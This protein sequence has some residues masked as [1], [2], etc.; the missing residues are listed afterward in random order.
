[1]QDRDCV[2]FLRRVLPS[3]GFRWRGYRKVRRQVCR[4][5]ARRMEELGL[6]TPAEYEARLHEDDEERD[7]LRSLCRV[8][9]SR[10]W[11]DRGM[12]DYLGG[13][14][15]PELATSVHQR[16]EETLRALSLGSASGEEPYSLSILWKLKVDPELPSLM[17]LLITAAEMDEKVI[18][19]ARAGV[20]P[21]SSVKDVPPDILRQAFE[22]CDG[23][24]V[25]QKVF[26]EDVKFLRQ[27]IEREL[28]VGPFHLVLC[29]NL[30]FTYFSQDRQLEM[31]P[32]LH[33]LL[34]PGGMLALGSH[35][36]LPYGHEG[37]LQDAR[38]PYLY[39]QETM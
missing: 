1:M 30:V 5:I 12:W 11:R 39:L 16:G 10:F 27:D 29:R 2:E 36:R 31:L 3:L 6:L 7:V 14:I 33:G 18:D 24:Y 21:A 8:T 17:K 9:I 20:Y 13:H 25:L 26:S 15:L 22:E 34:V 19:R 38:V 28:P 35:E 23:N 37:F 4:R 32:R